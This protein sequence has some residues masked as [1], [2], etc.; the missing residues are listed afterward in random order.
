MTSVISEQIVWP[1]FLVESYMFS[2]V[3]IWGF[4]EYSPVK[5]Y[6]N[7]TGQAR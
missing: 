7:K 2:A 5:L 1:S 4:F 6:C 3:K